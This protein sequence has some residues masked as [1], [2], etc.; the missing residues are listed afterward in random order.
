MANILGLAFQ[1]I[2]DILDIV[3]TSKTLGKP[4][5]LEF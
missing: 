4:S 3:G 1:I 5:G 2:D